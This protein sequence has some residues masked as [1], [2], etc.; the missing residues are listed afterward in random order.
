MQ[1]FFSIEIPSYYFQENKLVIEELTIHD[2]EIQEVLDSG[3]FET[4]I[5]A[6]YELIY[7]HIEECNHKYINTILLTEEQLKI[8]KEQLTNF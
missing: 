7:D 5:D 3:E 2:E 8:L 6:I 1:K 4:E